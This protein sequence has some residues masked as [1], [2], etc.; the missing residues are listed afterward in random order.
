MIHGGEQF[1][2][3]I[4]VEAAVPIEFKYPVDIYIHRNSSTCTHI[5]LLVM[6]QV[7]LSLTQPFGRVVRPLVVLYY[8]VSYWNF[9]VIFNIYFRPIINFQLIFAFITFYSF[10]DWKFFGG[11]QLILWEFSIF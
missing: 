2:E 10:G 6:P 7:R 9:L 11:S 4:G 5:F 1:A 3:A 8:C